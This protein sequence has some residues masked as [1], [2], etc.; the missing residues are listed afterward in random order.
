V[1]AVIAALI[2]LSVFL[3]RRS[4]EFGRRSVASMQIDAFIDGWSVLR[5]GEAA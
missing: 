5:P 4:A 1:A 3:V 2:A